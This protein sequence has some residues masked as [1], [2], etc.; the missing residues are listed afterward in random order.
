MDVT[1]R[2]LK[3]SVPVQEPSEVYVQW[4]RGK[5]KGP[6][7]KRQIDQS[8]Q[9]VEFQRKEATI[10]MNCSFIQMPDQSFKQDPNKLELYCAG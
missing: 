9:V 6:M 10:T 7:K 8:N 4:I 2:V 5:Q 3:A 1:I